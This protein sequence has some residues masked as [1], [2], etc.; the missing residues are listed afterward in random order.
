MGN[1]DDFEDLKALQRPL[2]GDEPVRAERRKVL[3]IL[4]QPA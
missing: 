3:T 4:I 1:P 2:L